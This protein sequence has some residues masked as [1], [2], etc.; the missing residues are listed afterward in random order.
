MLIASAILIDYSDISFLNNRIHYLLLIA[1]IIGIIGIQF[2]PKLSE[3]KAVWM[4]K[5]ILILLIPLFVMF[6]FFKIFFKEILDMNYFSIL[7]AAGTII[8]MIIL[9][10]IVKKSKQTAK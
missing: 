4:A 3:N 8:S 9:I 10:Q 6:L 2:A 1:S 5:W 7:G